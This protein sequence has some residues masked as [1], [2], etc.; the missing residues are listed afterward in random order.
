M[1]ETVAVP[2][3]GVWLFLALFTLATVREFFVMRR[4]E[5]IR[6]LFRMY[7]NATEDSRDTR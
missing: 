2:T 6:D 7:L 4:D 1:S 3:L 5:A